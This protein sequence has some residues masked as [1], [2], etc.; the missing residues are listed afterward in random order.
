MGNPGGGGPGGGGSPPVW[1]A[2]TKLINTNKIETTILLFCIIMI[3]K[4]I[5]NRISKIITLQKMFVNRPK[6]STKCSYSTVINDTIV[7]KVSI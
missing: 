2:H 6:Y 1:A 7:K 3:Y 4:G 5:K